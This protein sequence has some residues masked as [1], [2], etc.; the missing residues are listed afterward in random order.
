MAPKRTY[1]ASH[2]AKSRH[3]GYLSPGLPPITVL[4]VE[5]LDEDGELWAVALTRTP[6]KAPLKP[7]TKSSRQSLPPGAA[8][9]RTHD[10]VPRIRLASSKGRA[11]GRRSCSRKTHTPG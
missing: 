1:R 10:E 8:R 9:R 11:A 7:A 2:D 6:S 3:K 4:S 5:R